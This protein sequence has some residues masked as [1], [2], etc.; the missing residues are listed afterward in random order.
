[1]KTFEFNLKPDKSGQVRIVP[2]CCVHIGHKAHNAQKA[3][4]WRDYILNTPGCYA[5]NLGDDVENALPGDE[6]HDS[7]M[8]DSC[9]SPRDQMLAAMEFREPLV[10]AGKWL[11]DHDSNHWW[12]SEAKTGVSLAELL[13]R[14]SA[15]KANAKIAWGKWQ[16][17]SK[18][19]VGKQQYVVHAWHGAGGGTTPEAALRKCRSMA[20]QV[21]AEVYLMGHFHQRI[22]WQTNRLIAGPIGGNAEMKEQ[23]FVSTGSFLGWH[24][25]YAERMGLPPNKL[26]AAVVILDSKRWDVKVSM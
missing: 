12:R 7:M 24:D 16:S 14:E 9:M 22:F 3:K 2:I 17:L 11:I 8:W 13:S 15:Q 4:E 19:H 21:E 10:R 23:T 26:G 25:T 20:T 1:M 18:L 6:K 5:Y